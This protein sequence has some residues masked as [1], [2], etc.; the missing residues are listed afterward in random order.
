MSKSVLASAIWLEGA[1]SKGAYFINA[2]ALI[3]H[4]ITGQLQG[5]TGVKFKY[6]HAQCPEHKQVIAAAQKSE[7]LVQTGSFCR[8]GKID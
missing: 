6:V 3:P 7:K 4:V 2:L 5:E 1:N 8:G